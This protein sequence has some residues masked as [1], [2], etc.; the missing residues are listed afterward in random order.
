[1]KGNFPEM[2]FPLQELTEAHVHGKSLQ[3]QKPAG[4]ESFRVLYLYIFEIYS[5][6]KAKGDITDND[7]LPDK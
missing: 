4:C 7:P 6:S 1:M 3:L 5:G 2:E